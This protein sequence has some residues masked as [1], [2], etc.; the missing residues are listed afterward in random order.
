VSSR[1]TLV[2]MRLGRAV[3]Y[4]GSGLWLVT[5]AAD[6]AGADGPDGGDSRRGGGGNSG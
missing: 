3:V 2:V 5:M 6:V 1:P 4:S